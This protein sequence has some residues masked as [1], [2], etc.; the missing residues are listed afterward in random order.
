MVFLLITLQAPK[1]PTPTPPPTQTTLS[2][3]LPK[4]VDEG[5]SAA[6]AKEEGFSTKRS[7]T[8][9]CIGVVGGISY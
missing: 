5:D 1:T 2:Q 3:A 7:A 9:T 4:K 6:D 8:T